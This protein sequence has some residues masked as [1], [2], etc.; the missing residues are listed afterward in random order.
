MVK[1]LKVFIVFSFLCSIACLAL[2][3]KIFLDRETIKLRTQTLEESARSVAGNLKAEEGVKSGLRSKILDP[4]TMKDPLRQL[5][6]TAKNRQQDLEDTRN[7][8]AATERVLEQTKDTLKSTEIQ[9][10]D[11]RSQIE[12]LENDKMNLQNELNLAQNKVNQQ[13]NEIA[14]LKE[15]IS[16]LNDTISDKENAILGLEAD[17]ATVT[18]ER[19]RAEK[20]LDLCIAQLQGN[21]GQTPD[22]I[23]GKPA[24]IVRVNGEWNFVVLDI[25]KEEGILLNVEALVHRGEKLIGKVRVTEVQEGMCI[26]DIR[27]DWLE[28]PIK[29][30]DT[31]FF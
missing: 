8:L 22:D 29:E 28:E 27:P 14:G 24:K 6:D 9:L 25:G 21:D 23:K 1:A 13:M 12:T 17:L 5:E 3:I 20:E 26:A 18:S 16:G 10:A 7:T 4:A 19:D 2:G 15:E 11:A 31:V 30:G